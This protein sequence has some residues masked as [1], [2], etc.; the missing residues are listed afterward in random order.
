MLQDK[1]LDALI[2][3]APSFPVESGMTI[4]LSVSRKQGFEDMDKHASYMPPKF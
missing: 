3:H 2:Q 1:L 4:P